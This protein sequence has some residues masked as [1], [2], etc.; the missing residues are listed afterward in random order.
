MCEFYNSEF[1]NIIFQVRFQEKG[2]ILIKSAF[3]PKAPKSF[4][5]PADETA[6]YNSTEIGREDLNLRIYFHILFSKFFLAFLIIFQYR[7]NCFL[8]GFYRF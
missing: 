5:S 6:L 4:C 7:E 2:K 8:G 3:E 1:H